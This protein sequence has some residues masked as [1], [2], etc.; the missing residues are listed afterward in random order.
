MAAEVIGASEIPK[1]SF[2]E[3]LPWQ[4]MGALKGGTIG[5]G[6]WTKDTENNVVNNELK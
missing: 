1:L 5:E 2:V 6:S 4:R 3:A